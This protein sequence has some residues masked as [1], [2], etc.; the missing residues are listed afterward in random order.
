MF[1]YPPLG[2]IQLL[3]EYN[4]N[5]TFSSVTQPCKLSEKCVTTY[6]TLGQGILEASLYI[7]SA[8]LYSLSGVLGNMVDQLV[9]FHRKSH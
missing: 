1:Q 5:I 7:M 9:V 6:T 4:L 8:L 2:R 3:V